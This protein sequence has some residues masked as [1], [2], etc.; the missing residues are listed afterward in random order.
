MT[1]DPAGLSRLKAS[2]TY[3]LEAAADLQRLPVKQSTRNGATQKRERDRSPGALNPVL[4]A[5]VQGTAG[6]EISLLCG[7]VEVGDT[8]KTPSEATLG[9]LIVA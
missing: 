9:G 4:N 8:K 3:C 1:G 5:L 2:D 6:G 7:N